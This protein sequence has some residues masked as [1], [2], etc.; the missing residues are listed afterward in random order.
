MDHLRGPGEEER[1]S[2]AELV[3]Q[4]LDGSEAAFPQL[5]ERY[6]RMVFSIAYRGCRNTTDAED[7]TQESFLAALSSL[8]RLK[9]HAKFSSWLYGLALNTTRSFVRKRSRS[10]SMPEPLYEEPADDPSTLSTMSGDESVIELRKA[11]EKLKPIYRAVVELR[12]LQNLSCEEIALRLNEPS[13]TIRS[14]LCRASEIL[15]R[16]MKKFL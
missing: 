11:V 5:I 10:P 1:I 8:P 4:V 16:K 15:R 2:D 12:Y 9:D 14:R 3:A 13:G 6:W 7:I